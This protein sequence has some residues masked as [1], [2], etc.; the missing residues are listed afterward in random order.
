MFPTLHKE[1][2][3]EYLPGREGKRTGMPLVWGSYVLAI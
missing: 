2:F 1:T 3:S